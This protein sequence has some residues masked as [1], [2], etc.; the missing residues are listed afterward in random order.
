MQENIAWI[1]RGGES[2]PTSQRDPFLYLEGS[3]V[4][5][6][7]GRVVYWSS[8]YGEEHA[9]A[10]NVPVLNLAVLFLGPGCSITSE[11]LEL[12]FRANVV[13]GITGGDRI[14]FQGDTESV[15]FLTGSSE[16]R[17]TEYMQS[18]ASWWFSEE[19]RLEKAKKLL[20]IR[21]S[22]FWECV[23]SP[24]LQP[25]YAN[26]D[27][28]KLQ[29]RIQMTSR[30]EPQKIDRSRPMPPQK[31]RSSRTNREISAFSQSVMAAQSTEE[32]L[33][34]E[35]ARCKMLYKAF[36]EAN[37]I[38]FVRDQQDH[39]GVN[40][41]LNQG[42]YL[43]YGLAAGVLHTLGISFAF[44]LL[45]GK[46]RRGGLVFDIADV[47][48]DAMV[49][50]ISFALRESSSSEYR[51]AIKNTFLQKKAFPYLFSLVKDLSKS[52]GKEV[53]NL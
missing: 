6:E 46:T 14:A 11:A 1:Y 45:H 47:I 16:Y 53:E 22:Y 49:L 40:G 17:P 31:M 18:W 5:V 4:T 3:R 52:K 50:P 21:E 48:K 37:G 32:L 35:G 25:Y 10:Y 13:V 44:P 29:D 23:K 42:N 38:S 51:R 19:Q 9:Y 26:I 7:D 2:I 41:Q 15:H 27:L 36:S 28:E 24:A 39:S 34:L 30:S 12:L 8:T 33:G 43:A 20:L